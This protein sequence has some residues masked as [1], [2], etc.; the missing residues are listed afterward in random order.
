MTTF[1]N[2]FFVKPAKASDEIARIC[3]LLAAFSVALL[4]GLFVFAFLIDLLD[5]QNYDEGSLLYLALGL[6]YLSLVGGLVALMACAFVGVKLGRAVYQLLRKIGSNLDPPSTWL[7]G[8]FM[9]SLAVLF[10]GFA[11][12]EF[13]LA[14]GY[15]LSDEALTRIGLYIMLMLGCLVFSRLA[16]F[17]YVAV[18]IIVGSAGYEN[19]A[20]Q[21]Y[22]T[23]S[24]RAEAPADNHRHRV[25]PVRTVM[26]WEEPQAEVQY[27]R[28]RPPRGGRFRSW[29]GQLTRGV[30]AIGARATNA[31]V[32]GARGLMKTTPARAVSQ[33]ADK[34][35][36]GMRAKNMTRQ[37]T[38]ANATVKA[39]QTFTHNPKIRK[40]RT[41]VASRNDHFEKHGQRLPGKPANATEY[42]RQAQRFMNNPPRGTL[43]RRREGGGIIRYNPKTGEYGTLTADGRIRT[44]MKLGK[45]SPSNP[46]G[47]SPTRFRNN[48]EYFYGT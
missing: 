6:L 30:F 12:Y 31:A 46:N 18:A 21:R 48:K 28:F 37:T 22:Y 3:G 8:L 23:Q 32:R 26:V 35:L 47:Y 15:E 27:V 36:R 45:E 16:L 14:A 25:R 5:F 9:P 2:A 24:V 39:K 43:T 4:A 40:R 7:K 19:F 34:S 29:T 10:A 41:P 38:G 17:G 33:V 13:Y 20:E 1:T 11:G 42:A 44:Y